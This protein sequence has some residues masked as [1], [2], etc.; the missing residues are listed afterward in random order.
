MGENERKE[1]LLEDIYECYHRNIYEN[2]FFQYFSDLKCI[3]NREPILRYIES[4]DVHQYT[5][6]MWIR[7]Y[8]Y[9]TEDDISEFHSEGEVKNKLIQYLKLN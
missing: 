8:Q 7:A 6:T 1:A 9:L 5:L 4:T 2:I 3:L